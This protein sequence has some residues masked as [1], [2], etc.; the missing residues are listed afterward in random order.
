MGALNFQT[1]D[2]IFDFLGDALGADFDAVIGEGIGVAG[3]DDDG[4]A[5]LAVFF[6]EGL[7]EVPEVLGIAPEAEDGVYVSIR[8]YAL[9][10]GECADPWTRT[11]R[12][13]GLPGASR[14]IRSDSS[15]AGLDESTRMGGCGKCP[16]GSSISGTEA[17][18]LW[19]LGVVTTTD[20]PIRGHMQ[21]CGG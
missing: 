21:P 20:I 16:F 5:L 1:G 13:S 14:S 19:V 15:I 10:I 3:Y 18:T 8:N 2:L 9:V 6:F 11:Q 7:P 17:K 12:W 4:E